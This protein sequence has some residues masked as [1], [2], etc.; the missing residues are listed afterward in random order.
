MISLQVPGKQKKAELFFTSS[1]QPEIKLCR[2]CSALQISGDY[3][4]SLQQQ[5]CVPANNC[6]WCL[7]VG[8]VCSRQ[9]GM[10]FAPLLFCPVDMVKVVDSQSVGIQGICPFC[11]TSCLICNSLLHQGSQVD[12]LHLLLFLHTAQ[13]SNRPVKSPVVSARS[14]STCLLTLAYCHAMSDTLVLLLLRFLPSGLPS[15]HS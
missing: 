13:M 6:M 1:S 5:S 9:L 8:G 4:H 15:T 7:V 12:L 10:A 3:C 14:F 11:G 2:N